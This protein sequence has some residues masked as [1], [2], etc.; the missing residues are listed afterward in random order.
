[1]SAIKSKQVK[2]TVNHGFRFDFMRMMTQVFSPYFL[3]MRWDIITTEEGHSFI[4][5]D[6]PV[7]FFNV[8]FPPPYE[9]GL[10]LAGT[11]VFFPVDSQHV[12]WM[13]HPELVNDSAISD[14]AKVPEARLEDGFVE[15]VY[16]TWTEEKVRRLNWT[17]LELSNR[18][19]VGN[20]REIIEQATGFSDAQFQ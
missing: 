13:R 12:L 1:V 18:I 8:R 15:V 17:M 6:S 16:E 20:S 5:S 11:M 19:V 7:T 10:T 2:I 4:T 14:S 3:R 9:P